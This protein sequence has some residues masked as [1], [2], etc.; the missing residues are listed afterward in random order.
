[1]IRNAV[2][3]ACVVAGV[4]GAA[5][6][7]TVEF[8]IVERRGQTTW[9]ASAATS[10]PLNDSLFN[11]AV[12]ARVV[13]SSTGEALGNFSF[14]VASTDSESDGAFQHARI[15]LL[16]GTYNVGANQ[17]QGTGN[18][19]GSGLAVPYAYLSG[20]NP[21]FNGLINTTG[22]SFV[23]NPAINEMGLVTGSPTGDKLL[24]VLDTLGNGRPDTA[25]PADTSATLDSGAAVSYFGAGGFVD[26]YH[27]NYTVS[28][29]ATRQIH[30]E[31]MNVQAQTFASLALAN[32]VWG[33]ANPVNAQSGGVGIDVNVTPAPGAA[34]LLGLGGFVAARRR[35]TA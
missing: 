5:Q 15:S 2:L 13:G 10:V 14:D 12:Q 18:I 8:R 34:A 28:S 35:R 22:G 7:A 26:V 33:P 31:L 24:S 29:T 27:F 19:L 30:F 21:N 17:Y 16:D 32:G 11:F 9:N 1:M 4:A 3:L 6:A 20:I 25:G 23:N